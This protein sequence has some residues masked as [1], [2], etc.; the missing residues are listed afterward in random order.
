MGYACVANDY[1]R[2]ATLL[3]GVF[4]LTLALLSLA[5]WIY[6]KL[7]LRRANRAH[8]ELIEIMKKEAEEAIAI[9]NKLENAAQSPSPSSSA[10]KLQS[11]GDLTAVT[12]SNPIQVPPPIKE[13]S[14]GG[15]QQEQSDP[16]TNPNYESPCEKVSNALSFPDLDNYN[17]LALRLLLS[18]GITAT[19][20]LGSFFYRCFEW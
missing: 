6:G 11:V 8:D 15:T 16:I 7:V 5:T 18:L 17:E 3:T 12:S 13:R 10:I 1:F 19:F 4:L 9:A 14:F 2:L 20:G